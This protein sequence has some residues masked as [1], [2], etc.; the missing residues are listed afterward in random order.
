MDDLSSLSFTVSRRW[1]GFPLLASCGPRRP[2]AFGIGDV[3]AQ[4]PPIVRAT[5]RS[6]PARGRRAP[7]RHELAA[8]AALAPCDCRV[9]RERVTVASNARDQVNRARIREPFSVR[10]RCTSTRRDPLPSVCCSREQAAWSQPA[11]PCYRKPREEEASPMALASLPPGTI[12]TSPH[13]CRPAPATHAQQQALRPDV[14][15]AA[16]AFIDPALTYARSRWRRS[17]RWP[18]PSPDECLATF[19]IACSPSIRSPL[20]DNGCRSSAGT[21]A[22][23]AGN[24]DRP[25]R[26]Q[27]H[28]TS[29]TASSRSRDARRRGSQSDRGKRG[30][31]TPGV[32]R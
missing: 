21:Y 24:P 1:A 11:D 22:H 13:R 5:T 23:R 3:F 9:R 4:D 8:R 14:P 28:R 10:D 30:S 20:A 18:A 16:I 19:A 17:A 2:P 6:P 31:R 7:R 27:A 15:A 29:A 25:A 26:R 12:G 32:G